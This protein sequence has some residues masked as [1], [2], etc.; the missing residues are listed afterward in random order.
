MDKERLFAEVGDMPLVS[1]EDHNAQTG[2]GNI[3][4]AAFARVGKALKI[5]SMGVTRYGLSGRNTDVLADM[6]LC[7]EGIAAAVREIL[8]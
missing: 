3:A 8:K 2:I 5:K 4:A 7:A 6:G 1:C